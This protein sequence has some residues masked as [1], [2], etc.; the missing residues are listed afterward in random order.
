MWLSSRPDA[1]LLAQGAPRL[2]HSEPGTERSSFAHWPERRG[3]EAYNSRGDFNPRQPFSELK[4]RMSLRSSANRPPTAKPAAVF[5]ARGLPAPWLEGSKRF[6]VLL[7]CRNGSLASRKAGWQELCLGNQY[8]ANSAGGTLPG[9]GSETCA[10]AF[11]APVQRLVP[12]G[13]FLS[14]LQ[15]KSREQPEASPPS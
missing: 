10:P 9:Q 5:P 14:V 4:G 12:G 7:P 15:K 1:G 11:P 2:G 13:E 3:P 6:V 8:P